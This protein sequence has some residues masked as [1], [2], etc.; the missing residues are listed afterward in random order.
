MLWLGGRC[1]SWPKVVV[2]ND[3]ESREEARRRART[4]R[5]SFDSSAFACSVR[6]PD[7][8]GIND[9]TESWTYHKIGKTGFPSG[10]HRW[11]PGTIGTGPVEEAEGAALAVAVAAA[12]ESAARLEPMPPVA[13]ASG[14]A[15]AGAAARGSTARLEPVPPGAEA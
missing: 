1:P 5:R 10:M 14:E 8:E 12:R 6:V 9:S 2:G 4:G 11:E 3:G 13:E 7:D 15:L